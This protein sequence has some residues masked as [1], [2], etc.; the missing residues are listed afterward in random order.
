MFQRVL[1]G[2]LAVLQGGSASCADAGA[3]VLVARVTVA[4]AAGLPAGAV[5]DTTGAGDAF[6]GSILYGITAGMDPQQMMG[7]AAAVAACKCTAL[8]AR[9]GL[10]NTSQLAAEML[11]RQKQETAVA[12]Q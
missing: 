10:P 11:Q 6:I 12:G 7:L 9:P 2:C 4:S 8:G 5:V 1:R 3:A